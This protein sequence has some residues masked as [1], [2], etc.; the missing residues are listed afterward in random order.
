MTG[1]D[2]A[3]GFLS[4]QREPLV[5]AAPAVDV[6]ADG[7]DW[8]VRAPE[9]HVTEEAQGIILLLRAPLLPSCSCD[10]RRGSEVARELFRCSAAPQGMRAA[11]QEGSASRGAGIRRY[12]ACA[13]Q[14]MERNLMGP[15]SFLRSITFAAHRERA[16]VAEMTSIRRDRLK[17]RCHATGSPNLDSF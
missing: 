13:F 6:P 12:Q 15:K 8:L 1:Q 17:I 7:R 3:V 2:R 5:Q 14:G 9:A 10:M 4:V 11:G 16:A